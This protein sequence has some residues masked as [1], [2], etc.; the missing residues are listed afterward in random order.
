VL[1][2]ATR[3]PDPLAQ[4]SRI[5]T[6]ESQI[7]ALDAQL[8]ARDQRIKLLEETLRLLKAACFGV[9]R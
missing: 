9:S 2:S 7:S 4:A 6:L 1:E 8:L 3:K 5:A